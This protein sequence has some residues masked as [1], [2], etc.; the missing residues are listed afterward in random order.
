MSTKESTGLTI[1]L[2]LAFLVIILTMVYVAS[3]R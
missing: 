1:I 3:P 2:M